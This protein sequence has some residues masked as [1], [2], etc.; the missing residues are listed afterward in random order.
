MPDNIILIMLSV[1]LVS[2]ISFVGI[3]A[4]A[5]KAKK[6][7]KILLYLI[8]FSAGALLGDTFIHLLPE[9]VEKAGF[10]LEI[11]G[12]VL[13]GIVTFFVLEKV[14]QWQHCH[15]HF[16]EEKHVHPFAYMNIVGDGIHNFIDGLVIAVSYIISV[17]VGLATTTAVALHEIPQE[18]GDFGVLLHG[19]FSKRRALL[20]NFLSALTA[21]LGAITAVYLNGVIENIELFLVPVAAGGFIYIAGSDLIPE[22][23]K[24]T[25][26]K[27][28]IVQLFAFIIGIL[29]MAL[30]LLFD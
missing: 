23:H 6:L 1:I 11:S 27:K 18:I 16:V 24:E 26:I 4:I 13:F 20:V 2:L 15:G 12:Y 30:L 21:V 10:G 28:S 14:I 7:N 29:I 9:T 17:P 3:F 25:S 19:G 22:L 5:I 8:S